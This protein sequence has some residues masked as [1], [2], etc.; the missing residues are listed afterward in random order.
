MV[1]PERRAD[2]LRVMVGTSSAKFLLSGEY[3]RITRTHTHTMTNR[4]TAGEA[5]GEE[6]SD[7]LL[8]VGAVPVDGVPV[9]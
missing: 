8:Y 4:S 6:G 1:P 3:R 7:L 9:G 5:W 2:G